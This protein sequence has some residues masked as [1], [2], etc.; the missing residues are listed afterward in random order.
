[1]LE[2]TQRVRARIRN[3]FCLQI[4]GSPRELLPAPG[5]NVSLSQ[6]LRLPQRGDA[7]CHVHKAGQHL[8]LHCRDEKTEV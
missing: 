1:M 4:V 7:V 3:Q 2:V 6:H 5:D 8:P